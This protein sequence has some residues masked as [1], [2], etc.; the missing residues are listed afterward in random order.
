MSFAMLSPIRDFTDEIF[1][2][3]GYDH[4]CGHGLISKAWF[5]LLKQGYDSMRLTRCKSAVDYCTARS[6]RQKHR[7]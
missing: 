7:I 6:G 2:V 5:M 1:K 3:Q 4:H